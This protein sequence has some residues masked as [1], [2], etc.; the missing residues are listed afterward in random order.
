MIECICGFNWFIHD[1]W[2]QNVSYLGTDETVEQKASLQVGKWI[3]LQY[4][5]HKE[6]LNS[7][8]FLANKYRKKTHKHVK[9]F[10][11]FKCCTGKT[12]ATWLYT[13]LDCVF[14]RSA[15]HIRE[16][17]PHKSLFRQNTIICLN[18]KGT[19]FTFSTVNIKQVQVV[20]HLV[21]KEKTL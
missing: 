11:S 1:L 2:Q 8:G 4:V 3:T 21:I 10:D 15:W 17:R 14:S 16:C 7:T 9:K 13:P 6:V 12:S 20:C 5:K 19:V 18:F